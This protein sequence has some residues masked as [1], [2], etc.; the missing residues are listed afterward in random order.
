MAL[1]EMIKKT[2]LLNYELYKCDL[3]FKTLKILEPH[4][5]EK[6]P[7]HMKHTDISYIQMDRKT[8][9]WSQAAEKQYFICSCFH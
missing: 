9:T 2:C 4:L 3:S 6:H 1:R 5:D 8:L 7:K